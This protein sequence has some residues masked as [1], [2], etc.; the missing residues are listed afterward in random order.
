ML[1]S[2]L[3]DFARSGAEGRQLRVPVDVLVEE[4]AE[5]VGPAG[6]AGLGAE[7]AEPE[8]VARLDLEW[9][10]SGLPLWGVETSKPRGRG[11]SIQSPLTL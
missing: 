4:V 9:P 2:R 5:V 11:T 7:G 8:E 1:R 6:V 10:Q 3:R